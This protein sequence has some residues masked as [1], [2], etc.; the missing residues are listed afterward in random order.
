[1]RAP[2][3]AAPGLALTKE[4]LLPPPAAGQ[5]EVDQVEVCKRMGKMMLSNSV[6]YVPSD[7]KIT[8]KK[9]KKNL[10]NIQFDCLS[11]TFFLDTIV[12]NCVKKQ[13]EFDPWI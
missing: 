12:A 1:M 5:V 6:F 8:L 3:G 11:T 2:L 7:V 4:A 13:H 9:T 10:G